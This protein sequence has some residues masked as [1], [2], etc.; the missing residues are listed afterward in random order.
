MGFCLSPSLLDVGYYVL[1]ICTVLG[2]LV[3][4]A[5]WIDSVDWIPMS[6]ELAV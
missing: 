1:Y 6:C 3:H 2:D 4:C 5:D